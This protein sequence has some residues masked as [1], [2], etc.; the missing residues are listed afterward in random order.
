MVIE[1]RQQI[2]DHCD[3]VL[4]DE[5]RV[6]AAE[7]NLVD[8]LTA[9]HMAE[10]FQALSDPTRV[11]IISTLAQQELCVCDLAAVL[12]MSQSAISHQ[13]RLLRV[14]GLVRHRKEGRMVYYVLDDEHIQHLF[15]EGLEHARHGRRGVADR[16]S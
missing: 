5:A 8:G 16:S 15:Q 14:M 13:L 7:A 12:G 9:T 2:A 6:R 1:Y 3:V 4:V 11:R 10:T